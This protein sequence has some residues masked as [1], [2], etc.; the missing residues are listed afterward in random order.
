MVSEPY[1]PKKPNGRY[2]LH[3]TLHFAL[4][5][6][7]DVNTENPDKKSIML[8]V[9]CFFQVLPHGRDT[10]DHPAVKMSSPAITVTQATPGVKTS[11]SLQSPEVCYNILDIE[12]VSLLC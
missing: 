4:F 8:Y 6:I 3:R 11:S 10:V 1:W 9:M 7:S 5:S 2:S 12:H